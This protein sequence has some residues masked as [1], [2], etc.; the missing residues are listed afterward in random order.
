MKSEKQ[1]ISKY[2]SDLSKKGFKKRWIEKTPEE[3]KAHST[4]MLDKRYKK[5][6]GK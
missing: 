4:M 5:S 1:I 6:S 2:M 3:K